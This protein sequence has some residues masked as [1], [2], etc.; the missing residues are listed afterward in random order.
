MYS[1]QKGQVLLII[2]LIMIVALTVGLSVAVRSITNIKLTVDSSNSQKAFQAAE[3]GIEEVLGSNTSANIVAQNFSPGVVINNVT[4]T[5][6]SGSNVAGS[7]FYYL[8]NNGLA[9]SQDDGTDIWLST[10]NSDPIQRYQNPWSGNLTVYWGK[11]NNACSDAALEI[12]IISGSITAPS[13]A[14][15]AVDP[16][17]SRTIGST[18]NHFSIAN[19]T[20]QKVSSQQFYY[21]ST[22]TINSGLIA[23]IVPLYTST[24]IAISADNA[25][26]FPSQGRIII[27]SATAGTATRKLIFFQGY[28]SIPSEFFYSLF[29]TQ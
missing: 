12:M 16:C 10:Y 29:S 18:G 3:A 17:G 27:S 26:S 13:F 21:V 2:I 1:T 15:Y 22:I 23:R 4:I 7:T 6:V 25:S 5:Q 14:R 24:P 28:D 8:E 19:A 11:G 20:S 9:V